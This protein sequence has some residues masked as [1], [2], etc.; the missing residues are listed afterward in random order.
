MIQKHFTI[1][2]AQGLHMRPATNFATAMSHFPCSVTIRF[3][4]KEVNAKSPMLIMAACIKGGSEIDL[5]CDGAR[6]EDAINA[7]SS[8]I[9][10]GFGE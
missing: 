4:G 6:E 2:N 7:A 3:N 1:K 10:N 5:V 8:M 9:E